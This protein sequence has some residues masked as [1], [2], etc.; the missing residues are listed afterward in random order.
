MH[1][2][3]STFRALGRRLAALCAALCTA[4][5]LAAAEAPKRSFDL[6]A[7]PAGQSLKLFSEQS[8]SGLLVSTDLTQGVTTNTVRGAF[9]PSEALDRMLA[10]TGLIAARDAKNGAFVVKREDAGPN[11][12][13][14]APQTAGD[15]PGNSDEKTGGPARDEAITMSPFEVS[16][17][18]DRGYYGANTMAGTRL[19]SK[20]E[21][22]ASSITVITKEQMSDFALL[23]MNDIFNYEASTEGTGNYTDFSFDRNFVSHDNTELNPGNANRIRG[24][25]PAN[26]T[27]GSFETSGRTPIDP[28]DI[29][30][31][32]ISRGPNSSLFGIGN[33]AGTVNTVRSSANLTKNASRVATRVDSFEGY[34]ASLDLN[35]VLKKDVLAVRGSVVFQHDGFALKPSGTDSERYNAMVKFRPFKNTSISASY[36]Y[37]HLYG[38]RT[39][40]STPRDAISGWI[41]A[42]S[43]TW[44]PSTNTAR[45]NGV[46]RAGLPS[47]LVRVDRTYSLLFLD[48]TGVSHWSFGQ[49]TNTTTPISV[50]GNRMLVGP[51]FDTARVQP[52]IQNYFPPLTSKAIYDWSDINLSAP[53]R[54]EDKSAISSV[55]LDQVLLNSQRHSLAVQLGWF[56]E[57]SE[58]NSRNVYGSSSSGITSAVQIDVNERF[59]DGRLNPNFLRPMYNAAVPQSTFAPIDRDTY[60]AQL[61]YK[62]DLGREKNWLRWLGSHQVSAYD[63]Y[64]VIQSRTR[65][66]RDA[67]IDDHAWI[68]AGVTRGTDNAAGGLAAGPRVAQVQLFGYVGDNQGHNVEYGPPGFRQGTYPLTWGNG[69]TG[70]FVD[71]PARIGSAYSSG[72][73]GSNNWTILKSRGEIL[74]SHFLSD[75]IITTFGWRYDERFSRAG[76]PIRLLP[77]GATLDEASFN[78]WSTAN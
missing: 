76:G 14:A 25:G 27:F 16:G 18:D 78:S 63:E 7:G 3:S 12:G 41:A 42:G 30:A 19:N 36:A 49:S 23:D 54:V 52:L 73:G 38:N 45:V 11:A 44:D 10:G 66:Y 37:Y 71:E 68:A 61:A 75:R 6:P 56:R 55:L 34:R 4:A 39:N 21:D 72:G 67:I 2:S 15:R 28:V 40:T 5:F 20:I 9:T 53:N 24:I 70:A 31:V 51:F 47:S 65:S 59:M 32:E 48:Q 62:L 1:S 29:D 17:A 77:D 43:P 50:N 57:S 33:A 46:P 74:Q 64:K 60:R 69:T 13:R 35:R 8:G 22:L 58:R 26:V